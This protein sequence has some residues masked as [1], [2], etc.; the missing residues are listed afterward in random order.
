MVRQQSFMWGVDARLVVDA[1]GNYSRFDTYVDGIPVQSAVYT[2]FRSNKNPFTAI[3]GQPFSLL[4]YTLV[5]SKWWETSESII[6]YDEAG[7]P[8]FFWDQD[9]SRTKMKLGKQNYL[10]DGKFYDRLTGDL[11]H[12]WFDYEDCGGRQGDDI[13]SVPEQAKSGYVK[14]KKSEFMKVMMSHGK[15]FREGLLRL[16]DDATK[17]GR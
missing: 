1:Q 10:V 6:F 14:N 5:F 7:N 15:A 9:P 17:K 3:S 13:S 16:R 8:Y 12:Y 11:Y 4:Y 2:H